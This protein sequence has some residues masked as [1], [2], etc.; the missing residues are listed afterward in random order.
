MGVNETPAVSIVISTYNRASVIA[1]ALAAILGGQEAGGVPYELI[2]VDNNSSDDTAEVLASCARRYPR[3][4]WLS[5]PRQGVSHGRNAGIRAALAPLVAFTDDDVEVAPGW[6][7]TIKRLFDEHPGV[8]C[9]GGPVLPIWEVEPPGWLDER[10]WSPTSVTDYGPMAFEITAARPRCLLTSNLA[11][12]KHIFATVGMFSPRFPRGQDHELQ[13]RCWLAGKRALYTPELVVRTRVPAARMTRT[14][15]RRWHEVN[16]AVCARMWLRE[17]S[18]P[19]GGL[20][21]QPVVRRMYLGVPGFLFRE[22]AAAVGA[23][24][25][26][27]ARRGPA[28]ERFARELAARHLLAYIAERRELG[29]RI[30]AWLAGRA[31]TGSRSCLLIPPGVNDSDQETE[32]VHSS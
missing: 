1:P 21:S 14:Y 28:S 3:M 4:R 11:M 15:H 19:G 31:G 5:E 29:G 30:G 24:I 8:D 32:S 10:H 13:L 25:A 16:G 26:A 22:L 7:A 20:R 6:V 9:I 2:V 27:I 18:V 23:W 17:R 12:R